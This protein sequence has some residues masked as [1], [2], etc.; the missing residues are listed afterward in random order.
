MGLEH[1]LNELRRGIKQE[2]KDCGRSQV[3]VDQRETRKYE[4]LGFMHPLS[5]GGELKGQLRERL[6]SAHRSPQL[7]MINNLHTI[8]SPIMKQLSKY[9]QGWFGNEFTR[10][11]FLGAF[12]WAFTEAAPR[13]HTTVLLLSGIGD[14][15]GSCRTGVIFAPMVDRWAFP[16]FIQK[17]KRKRGKNTGFGK[18]I[19]TV[20]PT[21]SFIHFCGVGGLNFMLPVC[22]TGTCPLTYIIS[23]PFCIVSF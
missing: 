4:A 3:E 20:V 12:T 14:T 23:R 6:L 1:V 21:H 17:S 10:E 15:F 22:Q 19:I 9:C 13:T 7:I 18:T 11:Q 16:I 5:G 2:A 8:L